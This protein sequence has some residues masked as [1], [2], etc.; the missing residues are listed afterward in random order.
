M[1]LTRIKTNQITD[2]A[3]TSAKLAAN[4]VTAGKL[5][6]NLTYGSDFTVTGNLTVSGTTTSVSTT[7]TR[8][9]DAIIALSA[10]AT[11]SASVDSGLLINRGADD[12]QAMIWDESEDRFVFANVGAEDGDTAGNV[13]ISSYAGLQAGAIVYGSLNDGT[14][15]LT[16]TAAELNL[17]D[18][19]TAG[20]IV[21][22]KAVIYGAAGEVNATKLQV[23]GV[24]ITATPAEI[25]VLAGVTA[26]TVL[27]SGGVVVDSNKD[28]GSFRNLTATGAI[29]GGSFVI[30]SADIS[31]AELETIDGVTAG[32]ASASKALV[33]DG[34]SDISGI[35][36]ISAAGL[37]LS[38]LTD[39][40]IVIAGTSGLLEDSASLTFNGT[41]F[42]VGTA[43]DVVSST[44]NTT[45]GG[46]LDVTGKTSLDG[47]VDLGDASGD[48]IA[49]LGTATFTPSAAFNGGFTTAS[50]QTVTF[51]ATNTISAG[52]NKITSVADPA[53]AQDAATK[54][55]VDS[56]DSAQTLDS[57]T[58]VGATTTN[59]ITVGSLNTDGININDNNITTTRTNDDLVLDPAGTG[60]VNINANRFRVSTSKTPATSVG[61]A[62]DQQ[63]DICWDSDYVYVCTANYDTSSN[64]WKRV[65]IGDTW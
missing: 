20:T 35:N 31:E 47:A 10:E 18:G 3:V 58:G 41:T 30:G 19:S 53:S 55:Y 11:G 42:E 28:I 24:D 48:A 15:T 54:A 16:A 27:A 34:S 59:S 26:G 45:I 46:T 7:N 63:G 57:I 49:V 12:N 22:S 1:A 65:V 43:F 33:L 25:N 51:G 13:S 6:N 56:A 61:S 9:E 23:G 29:T 64:I 38:D 5:A 4:S 32:T 21:N 60:T 44:G 2:G 37:T 14:T 17:V 50:G 40:R 36:D 39:N 62:G 52:S 8:V